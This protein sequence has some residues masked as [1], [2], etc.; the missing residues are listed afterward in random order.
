MQ[1]VNGPHKIAE[2]ADLITVHS[3]PGPASI[4]CFEPAINDS[5]RAIGGALLVA[6]LSSEDTLTS[7]GSYTQKTVEMA[8]KCPSVVSGF[9]CQKRCADDPAFLYWTPGESF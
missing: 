5:S 8:K 2:W 6:E 4:K 7:E 3:L 9:I 1:L